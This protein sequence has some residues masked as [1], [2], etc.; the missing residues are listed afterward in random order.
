MSEVKLEFTLS[1]F[2]LLSSRLLTKSYKE[3]LPSVLIILRDPPFLT[4]SMYGVISLS[5]GRILTEKFLKTKSFPRIESNPT[6]PDC[7]SGIV[8]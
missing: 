5:V 8:L 2:L 4:K 7:G 1:T 6:N 3:P